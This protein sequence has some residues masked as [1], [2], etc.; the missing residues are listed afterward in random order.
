MKSL[1]LLSGVAATVL[2]GAGVALAQS[3]Q[4]PERAPSAQQNAPA[5]KM[6]PAMKP[7]EKG[8]TGQASPG[9]KSETTGQGSPSPG[10]KAGDMK[11]STS[12]QAPSGADP[13]ASSDSKM[14]SSSDMNKS[15][16]KAGKSAT[17]SKS[18]D[19]ATDQSATDANKNDASKGAASTTDSKSTD[20]AQGA[21]SSTTGQGAA[22]S[23]A[24]LSTEQKTKITTTFKAAKIESVPKSQ[25]NVSISVGTRLPAT[26]RYQP[27]PAEV[28]AVYPQWRG[29]YVILVDG[30]YIIVEPRTHQIVYIIV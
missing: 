5:E 18:M 6:A 10:M 12:G 4:A 8:T 14:K 3:P 21:S 29:Y 2:I 27:V 19:K 9:A 26:L 22:A 30:Q 25:I 23:A 16:D 7:G 1:K 13:K 11:P 28:I 24:N 15:D 17:D 20:S